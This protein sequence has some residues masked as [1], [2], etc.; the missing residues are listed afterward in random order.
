[1]QLV[2]YNNRIASSSF[3]LTV[4]FTLNT[5]SQIYQIILHLASSKKEIII[6]IRKK[7]LFDEY[8]YLKVVALVC[9]FSDIIIL[10]YSNDSNRV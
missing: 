6:L 2:D 9:S 1:M 4:G 7:Y 8:F 5:C 10:F 3:F